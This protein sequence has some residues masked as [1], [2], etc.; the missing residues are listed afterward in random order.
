MTIFLC[1]AG[2]ESY[3]SNEVVVVHEDMEVEGKGPTQRPYPSSEMHEFARDFSKPHM[4]EENFDDT[5]D[6]DLPPKVAGKRPVKERRGPIEDVQPR[7][8]KRKV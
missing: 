6:Y 3:A 5:P 8:K 7:K 1:R 4:G 2:A